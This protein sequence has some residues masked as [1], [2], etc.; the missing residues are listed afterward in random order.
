MEDLSA[1]PIRIPLPT[2]ITDLDSNPDPASIV[3]VGG[4]AYVTLE[5]LEEF[6]PA[7]IG[8]VVV[9]DVASHT[10][11]STFNL[12]S[13]NPTNF[14]RAGQGGA[15]FVGTTPDFAPTTGCLEK[16]TT[17][18][19]PAATCLATAVALGGFVAGVAPA[20]DG[21]IFVATGQ[22]FTEGQVKRVAA[23]GTVE[24]GS[25]TPAGQQPTDI[26]VCGNFLV[27]SDAAAGGVR[28]YD[29]AAKTE[30]TTAALDVG[31]A[32]AFASGLA[33]YLVP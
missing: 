24:A 11:D 1:A 10:V 22:S 20:D 29:I 18:G 12:T 27:A 28:V 25:Y 19:T 15:L 16:I 4:K 30:L 9:I 2:V 5:H 32:P 3:I 7:S 26:A 13:N 8:Q 31:L 17:T 33:C 23:N 6:F 21:S 14:M